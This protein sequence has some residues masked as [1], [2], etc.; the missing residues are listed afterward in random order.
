MRTRED[1]L[2]EFTWL[3]PK[4]FGM[5]AGGV[6]AA[7]VIAAIKAG[8]IAREHVQRT[9][10]G[11]YRINPVALDLWLEAHAGPKKAVA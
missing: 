2:V 10:G 7:T 5:K 11:H 9:R 3:S 8:E 6:K 4:K 1:A